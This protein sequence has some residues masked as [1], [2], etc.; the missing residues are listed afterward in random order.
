MGSMQDKQ[1]LP[2]KRCVQVD[3]DSGAALLPAAAFPSVGCLSQA[4]LDALGVDNFENTADE[5]SSPQSRELLRAKRASMQ[6]QL[7]LRRKQCLQ[8]DSDSG[9]AKL[10]HVQMGPLPSE[11]RFGFN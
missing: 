11:D 9:T 4:E 3:S 2:S 10:E 1:M 6:D 7:M 5:E 8:S